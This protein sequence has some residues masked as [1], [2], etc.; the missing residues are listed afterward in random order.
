MY[1]HHGAMNDNIYSVGLLCND[2]LIGRDPL[3]VWKVLL[4]SP[5]K[6][7]YTVG[8]SGGVMEAH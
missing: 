1:D 3:P 6:E 7:I 5:G 8:G 4:C 2:P